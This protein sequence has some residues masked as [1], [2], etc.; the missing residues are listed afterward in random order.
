MLMA[1]QLSVAGIQ[2]VNMFGAMLDAKHQ[3]ETQRLFQQMTAEAHKDYHP[4]EGMCTFGTTVRSLANSERKSDLAQITVAGRMNQRQLLS[5]EVLSMEGGV[6][7]IRSRLD[8]FRKVYCERTDNAKGLEKLC[9][10][11]NGKPER[12]NIDVDY[13]RNIESRLTIETD[14]TKDGAALT[15][16]EEDVFALS[17]N[18]FAHNIPP[19]IPPEKNSW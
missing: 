6:S 15:E 14:F 5:G 8:K 17:A 19:R 18:L 12:R 13:T 7:D 9:P 4:S 16:D 10:S 2:Q 1:E 3:L 11:S